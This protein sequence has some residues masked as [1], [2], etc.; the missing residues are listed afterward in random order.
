MKKRNIFSIFLFLIMGICFIVIGCCKNDETTPAPIADIPAVQ[1]PSG[2]FIMGS[3]TSEINR[4][5]NEIQHQVTLSAFRMSKYEITNEQYAAFLNAESIG[6]NALWAAGA[7]PDKQLIYVSVSGGDFGLHYINS[8]W[9]PVAGYENYPVIYVTWYGATE[10][11]T[12]VGGRLPTEAEWEYA[13]RAATTTPFNTGNCLTDLQAHYYW[14]HPYNTCT[15]TST[16]YNQTTQKV[17]TYPANAFGLYDMHGNVHEW[18]SDWAGAYSATA[19][20]NPTGPA[21]GTERIVRGGNW[22]AFAQD[23][24]SAFRRS[25]VPLQAAQTFGFRI[26]LV[27]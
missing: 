2:T 17:G 12:Y 3:P 7:Y 1:I 22:S 25:F 15:N 10:F 14:G 19:Q 23:C 18:C 9:I 8:Q 24:R 4:V 13:C 26:V 27:P 21:I 16:K 6:G 5:N 20:T 11:A